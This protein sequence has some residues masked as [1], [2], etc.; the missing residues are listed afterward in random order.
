[1]SVHVTIRVVVTVTRFHVLRVVSTVIQSS[2][3]HRDYSRQWV[4]GTLPDFLSVDHICFDSV[5]EFSHTGSPY[6]TVAQI[7]V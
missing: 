6:E 4:I 7:P 1:M 5:L 3:F 2:G